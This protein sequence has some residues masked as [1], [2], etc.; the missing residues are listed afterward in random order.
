MA[1][2]KQTLATAEREQQKL[3]AQH[4]ELAAERA[5]LLHELHGGISPVLAL[6]A[7]LCLSKIARYAQQE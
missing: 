6:L 7:V 1:Q 4:I 5:D 3:P 2:L